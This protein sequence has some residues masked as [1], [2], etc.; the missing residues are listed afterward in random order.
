MNSNQRTNDSSPSRSTPVPDPTQLTTEAV[1]REIKQ[2]KELLETRLNGMDTAM[3]IFREE[4][5]R[6]PTEVD[7]QIQHLEAL[8]VEKFRT[9]D[10]KFASVVTRFNE[11]DV[12]SERESKDNKVAVDAALSA[13]KEAAGAQN[14]SNATAMTKSENG[15]TKQIDNISELIRT[16]ANGWDRQMSD[17]K[18]RVTR[19]E[20]EYVGRAKETQDKGAEVI[21]KQGSDKNVIALVGMIGGLLF[22]IVGAIMA[23][24][25]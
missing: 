15:F 6:S 13:Q 23:F 19:I 25:K 8:L 22:A 16:T 20:S 9:V 10:E 11:R 14:E 4:L 18:E 2:L 5:T 17:L 21:Q 7:R 3:E 24:M 12:R 1:T